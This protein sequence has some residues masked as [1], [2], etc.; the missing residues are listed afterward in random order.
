M[1]G[2]KNSKRIGWKYEVSELFQNRVPFVALEAKVS[3][4]T[5]NVNKIQAV[6]KRLSSG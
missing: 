1:L 4:S 5:V 6:E 2:F 3:T